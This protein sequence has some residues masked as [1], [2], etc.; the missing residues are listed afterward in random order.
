[1]I[2]MDGL[3]LLFGDCLTRMREIPDNSVDMIC[4]DPP[5][6]TMRGIYDWDVKLNT[7][8]MMQECFRV[9]RPNG[10][11]VLF[12]QGDYTCE[13]IKSSHGN[14]PFVY[15]YVWLK[16]SFGNPRLAK[17]APLNMF[18]DVCVYA[19][20]DVDHRENP[21][22][23]LMRNELERCGITRDELA[24][25]IGSGGVIHHFTTGKVFRIPSRERYA[26]IQRLTGG[27]AWSYEELKKIDDNFRDVQKSRYPRVFNLPD[28]VKYI[29]NVLKYDKDTCRL[30]PTQKPVD[31]LSDLIRTYTNPGDTVLDF[32]MGSGSTGVAVMTE[33][34]KFIGI[35][36]NSAFYALA[37]DRVLTHSSKL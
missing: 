9:L 34:R 15:R 1:M 24:E 25:K 16:D 30:H 8:M 29:T 35:E 33:D 14:M 27:F 20:A 17:K 22:Q 28:D 3:W 11:M 31:M 12:S 21:L 36:A 18:E 10:I 2:K 6:G 32:T 23:D 19:K 37:C 5:Y 13:L 4:T 7:K 26:D